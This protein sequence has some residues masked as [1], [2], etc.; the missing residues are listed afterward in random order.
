MA[1]AGLVC[2]LIALLIFLIMAIVF[3]ALI[4]ALFG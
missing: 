2:N 3:G 4:F 1:V